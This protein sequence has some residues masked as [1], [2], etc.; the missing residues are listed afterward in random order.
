MVGDPYA[1]IEKLDAAIIESKEAP[2]AIK[3]VPAAV[4]QKAD[5][6]EASE[7]VTADLKDAKAEE[8]KKL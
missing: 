5:L 4:E 6:V 1:T 7:Q 2:E 8:V 3:A